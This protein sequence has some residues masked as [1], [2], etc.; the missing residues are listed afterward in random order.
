MIQINGMNF[1]VRNG[2]VF[3]NGKH[4]VPADG[5]DLGVSRGG[6]GHV[7]ISMSGGDIVG[8]N[9]SGDFGEDYT[10]HLDKDGRVAGDVDGSLT[11]TGQNV[12][13]IIE[14]KVGGSVNTT[15]SVTCERVGGSVNAGSVTCDRVGGSV[16][17]AVVNKR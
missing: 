15:G 5:S 1:D 13:L 9:A 8:G 3:V 10:L 11:V 4:M 2:K 6:S 12:T 17:A 14:G 7:S 16:N